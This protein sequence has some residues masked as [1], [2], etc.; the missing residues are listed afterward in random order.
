MNDN[1]VLNSGALSLSESSLLYERIASLEEEN[2]RLKLELNSK[3]QESGDFRDKITE[4]Q[5]E[6]AFIKSKAYTYLK[7]LSDIH[8]KEKEELKQQINDLKAKQTSS[9]TKVNELFNSNVDVKGN[10][11]EFELI[12]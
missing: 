10:C 6:I 9:E 11:N 5:K 1:A 4:L 8:N 7:D 3:A 2:K 12:N